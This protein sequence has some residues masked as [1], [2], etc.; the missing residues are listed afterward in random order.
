MNVVTHGFA[1]IAAI[2]LV[3][4]VMVKTRGRRLLENKHYAAIAIAG[5]APDLLYPHLSLH[6]RYNSWTHTLWFALGFV[7]VALIVT[8]WLF[9]AM[10]KRCG[11][12]M[13]WAMSLHLFC[14]GIA[15]GIAWLYPFSDHVI[16][17][18]YVYP[19]NWI[20]ID[21]FCLATFVVCFWGLKF[22]PRS[23]L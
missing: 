17:K 19:R 21:I 8:R 23:Q 10:Q 6:A 3:E 9:P 14:D 7:P 11:L 2:A 4:L 20:T 18:Y 12:L 1:P 16:G 13:I 22:A 5:A 15:G